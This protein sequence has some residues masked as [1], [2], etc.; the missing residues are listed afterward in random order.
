[1]YKYKS[2]IGKTDYIPQGAGHEEV[3]VQIY[4][5]PGHVQWH[6]QEK[7]PLP[8]HT[9]TQQTTNTYVPIP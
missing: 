6:A 3:Y 9:H 7:D 5:E 8:Q 1:M 2:H 4:Y